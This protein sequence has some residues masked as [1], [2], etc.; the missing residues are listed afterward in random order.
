MG[1][2]AAYTLLRVMDGISG[3][4]NSF[5]RRPPGWHC[6]AS[7]A[8]TA[9]RRPLYSGVRSVFGT[10]M[11]PHVQSFLSAA[12]CS[13]ADVFM[14]NVARV[15]LTD[16]A[17]EQ[18]EHTMCESGPVQDSANQR[19]IAWNC[20]RCAAASAALYSALPIGRGCRRTAA[21]AYASASS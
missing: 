13:A 21:S 11:A 17:S 14:R 4:S 3:L 6:A 7:S 2:T 18:H 10:C 8:S 19:T 12:G 9:A 16:K 15:K 5:A 1:M 20:S